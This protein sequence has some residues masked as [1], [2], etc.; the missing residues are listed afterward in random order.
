MKIIPEWTTPMCLYLVWPKNL[1]VPYRRTNRETLIPFYME[2]LGLLNKHEENLTVKIILQHSNYWELDVRE[3]IEK[4]CPNLNIEF[5]EI[6]VQDIWIK[7][8]APIPLKGGLLKAIYAPDYCY[9]NTSIEDKAGK[10]IQ[11][12]ENAELNKLDLIWDIGNLTTNG[13][14]GF[15]TWKLFDQNYEYSRDFIMQQIRENLE[16]EVYAFETEKFDN[17]GHTDSTLRFLDK[18]TILVVSYPDYYEVEYKF[19]NELANDLYKNHPTKKIIKIPCTLSEKMNK[20]KI[21]SAEGAYLNYLRLGNNIYLPQFNRENEDKIAYYA[22]K[23]AVKEKAKVIRL[24]DCTDLAYLGGI[25]NC[26]TWV[27]YYTTLSED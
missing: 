11:I 21:Y 2:F 9:R 5:V 20:E 19:Y 23:E 7:D 14:I 8:W 18:D 6:R 22:I 1:R 15:V 24:P 12:I 26:M 3:R 4:T 16:M 13:E 27:N 17:I 25:I 10:I